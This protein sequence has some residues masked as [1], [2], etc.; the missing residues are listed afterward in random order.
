ME[1]HFYLYNETIYD[2]TNN[3]FIRCYNCY[4]YLLSI[5]RFTIT[6]SVVKISY[7]T[8]HVAHQI[9]SFLY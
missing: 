7:I 4:M 9:T 1:I 5:E 8:K 3:K 6:R 2:K